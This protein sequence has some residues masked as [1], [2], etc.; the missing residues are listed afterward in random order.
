MKPFG[1]VLAVL[2]MCLAVAACMPPPPV[3]E[4]KEDLLSSSGFRTISLNT[5][6]KVA[7][8]KKLPAHQ[9]SQKKYKGKN[10]W[11]YPDRDVCGCLYIGNQSAYDAYIKKGREKMISEAIK[12]NYSDD[13]YSPTASVNAL[14]YD[15]ATDPEAYGLYV[16]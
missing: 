12:A 2:G 4:S 3:T 11:V 13:P 15:W 7:A 14:D 10:V 9:L 16:D 1:S 8:F 5:P 6:A